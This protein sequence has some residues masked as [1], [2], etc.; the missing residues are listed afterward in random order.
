METKN[1]II[2]LTKEEKKNIAQKGYNCHTYGDKES[3]LKDLE[4]MLKSIANEHN[5]GMVMFEPLIF[6]SDSFNC[7]FRFI[8]FEWDFKKKLKNKI[9]N[10][11]FEFI[12]SVKEVFYLFDIH[13]IKAMFIKIQAK[14]QNTITEDF[15]KMLSDSMYLIPPIFY[16][17]E[18]YIRRF[19]K[20]YFENQKKMIALELFVDELN[21]T[22][23]KNTTMK[24]KGNY[25][26]NKKKSKIL[27][28]LP[29][30]VN[31]REQHPGESN[32]FKKLSEDTEMLKYQL[33][34]TTLKDFFKAQLK[35]FKKMPEFKNNNINHPVELYKFLNS[36]NVEIFMQSIPQYEYVIVW[37]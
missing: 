16:I 5:I 21:E 29:E 3:L 35:Y 13:N 6:V 37:E 33:K 31:Y 34:E 27:P 15:K 18:N 30:L 1:H 28:L 20:D 10:D 4:I 23:K 7:R 32:Y 19:D 9:K 36:R 8:D 14:D 22:L 25:I 11:T 12:E 24:Y 2:E 17:S 26:R